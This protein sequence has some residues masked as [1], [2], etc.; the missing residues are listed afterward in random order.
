[1]TTRSVTFIGVGKSPGCAANTPD[2]RHC[3]ISSE[4]AN[5]VSFIS[6]ERQEKVASVAVGEVPK[7]SIGATVPDE[8]LW[9][10]PEARDR[11]LPSG[12]GVPIS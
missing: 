5:T 12:T 8:V 1:V 11:P 9:G 2:G 3:V 4:L 7:Y 6:Y 10:D